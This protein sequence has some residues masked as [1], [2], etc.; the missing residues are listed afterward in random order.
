[1]NRNVIINLAFIVDKN[2]GKST[3]IDHLI[4]STGFIDQNYF[5]KNKKI[6]R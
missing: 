6:C 4:L 5:I 3:T 2:S 1:M